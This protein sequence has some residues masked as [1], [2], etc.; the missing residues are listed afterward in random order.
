[1]GKY[2]QRASSNRIIIEGDRGVG[3]GDILAISGSV[4]EDRRYL[5]VLNGEVVTL[6]LLVLWYL[7]WPAS[8]NR[9]KIEKGGEI[10]DRGIGRGNRSM[11]Q[12]S[13]RKKEG[14]SKVL[15]R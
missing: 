9:I 6:M 3:R 5:L 2:G 4:A 10:V 12:G 15:L 11:I 13:R 1:M 14:T 8:S 7:Q